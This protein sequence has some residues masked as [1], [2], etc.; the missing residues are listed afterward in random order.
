MGGRDMLYE[1]VKSQWLGEEMVQVLNV[2]DVI[3]IGDS[4]MDEGV[5]F[6]FKCFNLQCSDEIVSSL[7]HRPALRLLAL[8]S[9]G[10]GRGY[11]PT[12]GDDSAASSKSGRPLK[13][14]SFAQTVLAAMR[15]SRPSADEIDD[16]SE[17]AESKEGEP[18]E[19]KSV[20][21]RRLL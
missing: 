7:P 9:S 16:E 12:K 2:F 10:S 11:T 18:E 6:C 3:N 21:K 4:Q 19:T 20:K 5:K 17:A 14:K 1:Q 15:L 8:F 13:R